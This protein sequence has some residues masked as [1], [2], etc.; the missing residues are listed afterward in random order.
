MIFYHQDR[1]G[2]NAR[3]NSTKVV[4]V[5]TQGVFGKE[6]SAYFKSLS[7][8]NVVRNNVFQVRVTYPLL[9]IYLL[10]DT[11]H[12]FPID[13]QNQSKLGLFRDSLG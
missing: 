5:S 10:I 13:W 4:S 8:S 1:L 3:K 6:T 9:L 11:M 7:D 12:F 2:T